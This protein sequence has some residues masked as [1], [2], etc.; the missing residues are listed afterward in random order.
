MTDDL[1]RAR[2][3]LLPVWLRL[4]CWLC[5]VFLAVPLFV[6]LEM[7]AGDV[8]YQFY[9][10]SYVGSPVT[11]GGLALAFVVFLHGVAAYGL[12]WSKSWGPAL[13]IAVCG[14]GLAVSIHT[15]VAG[16]FSRVGPEP[17][18]LVLILVTLLRVRRRWAEM[19]RPPRS[20]G[21]A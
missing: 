19:E 5:L 4:L 12:L 1:G 18:V 8:H 20:G 9:G 21:R 3:N 16:G 17:V 14:V 6:P 2:R 15:L 10:V 11:P 13:G 7:A